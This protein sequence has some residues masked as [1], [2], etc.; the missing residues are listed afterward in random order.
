[1]KGGNLVCQSSRGFASAKLNLRSVDS[2][3][4][5]AVSMDTAFVFVVKL[6]SIRQRGNRKK[7]RIF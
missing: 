7:S 3:G 1:M 2:F 4:H 6:V 5:R